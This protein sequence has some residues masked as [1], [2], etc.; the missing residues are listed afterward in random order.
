MKH[1]SL[2]TAGSWIGILSAVFQLGGCQSPDAGKSGP[3]AAD[4]TYTITGK[5]EGLDSGWVYLRHRQLTDEPADSAPVKKGTFVLSGRA[6]VPEFVNIGFLRDGNRD[7]RAGFFLQHGALTFA[8]KKDSL[9]DDALVITG[10]PA[11]EEFRQYQQSQK[12]FDSIS[13]Q[14]ERRYQT[15][16]TKKDK[17]LR[18]SVIKSFEELSKRTKQSIKNYVAAHPSSYV[19]AFEV[20]SYFSYDPDASELDSIW[21]LMDSTAQTSYYGK[22]VRETLLAAQR[23]APGKPAPDFTL[24]D[25]SGK[26]VALSSLKGN[27]VLVDF[28]ASW[29]GPCR[30][31]NP[32]VV[33]A[34]HKYH[35]K[36]FAVLGVSLDETKDKWEEA[37]GKDHLGWAQVSDLKGWKSSVGELYG[38]KGIPMNFLLD[39][40]GKVIAKGLRGDDLEKK[41]AETIH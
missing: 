21:K 11:E 29:C 25:T 28:W 26:P 34:F 12:P 2:I 14:L 32:A 23:T 5:M 24:P 16:G 30:A 31:E 3:T 36:G 9:T 18:D 13:N 38:I 17:V 1:L 15:A 27:Y 37:I 41:L 20:D 6:T 33:K 7:Y 4:S 39:K 19:S 22:K 8:G 10:S 40:E 35:P